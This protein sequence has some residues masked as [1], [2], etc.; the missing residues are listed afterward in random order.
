MNFQTHYAVDGRLGRI[1]VVDDESEVRKPVSL[2]LKKAGYEVVEAENGQEAIQLLN[3]G[4]NPLMVDTIVCDIRMPK[5]SGTDA[6]AYFRTQY[7]SVPVVVLTGY[8][9]IELA[10]SFL[11]KGVLDY[12]VKPVSREELLGVIRKSVDQHVILKDQFVT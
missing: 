9:D 2:T 4:D 6:I 1:L 12:L 10:V 7:P 3:A 8:P 11:K 5:V